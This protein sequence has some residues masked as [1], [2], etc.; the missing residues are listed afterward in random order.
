M[1]GDDNSSERT[2]NDRLSATVCDALVS[3]GLVPKEK[4]DEIISKLAAGEARSRDWS[5]WR[6]STVAKTGAG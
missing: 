5:V 1:A 4:R 3:E 2:P 6:R